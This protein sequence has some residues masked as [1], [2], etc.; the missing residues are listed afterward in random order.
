MTIRFDV[1]SEYGALRHVIMG[2]GEGYHRD[3]SR[4]EIVNTTQAR[5]ADGQG[6][7]T[8]A[9]LVSEFAGFA[10]GRPTFGTAL[11][12][13]DAPAGTYRVT[14][15]VGDA[16]EETTLVVREDPLTRPASRS[17]R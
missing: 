7:P 1:R 15:E 11:G 3:P 8:E 6:H 10:A 14:L 16:T 12:S 17:G 4:V 2:R 5:T 9:R 13:I